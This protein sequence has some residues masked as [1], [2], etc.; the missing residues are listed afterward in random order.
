MVDI[1][2]VLENIGYLLQEDGTYIGYGVGNKNPDDLIKFEFKDH[3]L[4]CTEGTQILFSII[5]DGMSIGT[6]LVLLQEYGLF[7]DK[8]FLNA[9]KDITNK[10][11]K[12]YEV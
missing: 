6:L 10:F 12:E 7:Y 2:N 5:Y 3:F 1:I 4:V 11:S 9:I 8:N